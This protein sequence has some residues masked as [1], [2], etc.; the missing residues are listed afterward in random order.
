[1]LSHFYYSFSYYPFTSS[2]YFFFIN[3]SLF[4]RLF[5]VLLYS[6]IFFFMIRRPPRATLTDPLFPY[7]TLF[8]SARASSIASTICGRSSLRRLRSAV[9]FACPSA[10]IGIFST[11][12][13]SFVPRPNIPDPSEP[14]GSP[15]RPWHCRG[16][17]LCDRK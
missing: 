7:T 12:A 13:I 4:T 10:S 17:Q 11:V 5:F 16:D 9:S 3:F 1:M 6:F 2:Q 8:R 14:R 15:A